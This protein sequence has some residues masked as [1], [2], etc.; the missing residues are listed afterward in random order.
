M[1]K[2]VNV[3]NS[4]KVNAVETAVEAVV[5]VAKNTKVTVENAVIKQVSSP[6][7]LQR[8]AADKGINPQ[9]VFVRV[10]FEHAGKEFMVSNKL[11]FL[12]KAGY[13]E[14]INAQKDKTPVKLVVDVESGFF[15]IEHDV[16]VDDLFKEELPKATSTRTE[17]YQLI[18]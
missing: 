14:L 12:T 9:E 7:T 2:K 3:A 16:A 10:V 15:Y 18:I 5:K 1:A 17:L 6:A 8:V 4:K 11:R 13:V